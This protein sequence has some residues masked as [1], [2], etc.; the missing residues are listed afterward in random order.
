MVSVINNQG[1][2]YR[3]EIY[4]HETKMSCRIVR[5]PCVNNSESQTTLKEKEIYLGFIHLENFEDKVTI[6][7]VEEPENNGRVVEL[8]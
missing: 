5:T 2:F 7:I 8:S 4:I 1:G 3:T 6:S